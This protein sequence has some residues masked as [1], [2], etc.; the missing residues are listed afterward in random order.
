MHDRIEYQSQE[1]GRPVHGRRLEDY[2]RIS[3]KKEFGCMKGQNSHRNNRPGRAMFFDGSLCNQGCG[4]GLVLISPQG[5][6]FE[7]AYLIGPN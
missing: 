5:A 7:F 3:P 6:S 2:D 4:V 1:G